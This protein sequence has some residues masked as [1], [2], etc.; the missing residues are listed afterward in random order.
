MI[1]MTEENIIA[2]LE[3]ENM[4]STAKYLQNGRMLADKNTKTL[5]C[6]F[7]G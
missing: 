3:S 6:C 2:F 5:G 4:D 1:E 7:P